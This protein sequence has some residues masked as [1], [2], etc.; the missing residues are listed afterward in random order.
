MD[1]NQPPANDAPPQPAERPPFNEVSVLFPLLTFYTVGYLGLMAAEFFLR[2]VLKVPGGMMPV[3]VALVGAYAADKEIR[4][5]AGAAEPPRKGSFFVYLWMLFFLAA[6]LIHTFRPEFSIPPELDAIVLQILGIFFGSR[7]SKYIWESRWADD[8]RQ[9]TDDG[10]RDKILDMIKTRGRV[11]RREVMEQLGVSHS[12][13]YRL[14]Y[15]LEQQG[16]IRRMGDNKGTY[17]V[18]KIG[19]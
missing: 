13:A 3:Y 12:T 16:L 19:H 1:T 4:R 6:F 2:G 17:Y 10:G 18:L 5:W 14:L 11:T 7:A 15:A 9:T 8:R